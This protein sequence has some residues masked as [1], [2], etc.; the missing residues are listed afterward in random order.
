MACLEVFVAEY[1][2]E[3]PAAFEAL[4]SWIEANDAELESSKPPLGGT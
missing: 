4:E 1:D 3:W 2:D